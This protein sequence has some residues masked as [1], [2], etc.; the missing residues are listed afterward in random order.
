VEFSTAEDPSVTTISVDVYTGAKSQEDLDK[1]QVILAN[2]ENG[3][4]NLTIGVCTN[5]KDFSLNHFHYREIM[6]KT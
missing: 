1:M 5:Q 3:V 4:Y 2:S 6:W